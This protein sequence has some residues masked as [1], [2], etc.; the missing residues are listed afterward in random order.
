MDKEKGIL[1]IK[2]EFISETL[3][4][5]NMLFLAILGF[6]IGFLTNEI[7][8]KNFSEIIF[9]TCLLLFAVALI[10]GESLIESWRVKK[11]NELKEEVEQN[12]LSRKIKIGIYKR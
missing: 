9:F 8:N 7:L 1:E 11:Y 12:K 2:K 4:Y 6:I 10:A 3:K 5:E